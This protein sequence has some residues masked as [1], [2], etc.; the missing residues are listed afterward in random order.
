LFSFFDKT[1]NNDDDKNKLAYLIKGIMKTTIPY[2][3]KQ[4]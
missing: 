4:K 1:N 2:N 3:G